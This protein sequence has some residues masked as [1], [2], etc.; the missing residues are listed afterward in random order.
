[1]VFVYLRLTETG[2]KVIKNIKNPQC[3]YN[4]K[5][6]GQIDPFVVP[7]VESGPK[8]NCIPAQFDPWFT[9]KKDSQVNIWY[10][11]TLKALQSV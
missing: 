7:S 9:L 1:M 2:Q 3:K 10:K 4:D 5:S 8:A 6:I 11:L